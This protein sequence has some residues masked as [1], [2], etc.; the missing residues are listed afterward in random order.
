MYGIG[1]INYLLNELNETKIIKSPDIGPVTTNNP[2]AIYKSRYLSG[3]IKSAASTRS[4]RSQSITSE[5]DQL[6][7]Y[8]RNSSNKRK[9]ED[10][11]FE[12]NFINGISNKKIK[13]IEDENNAY[14]TKELEFDIDINSRQSKIGGY[15]TREIDFDI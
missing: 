9:F 4:L 5:L 10:N 6:D 1:K 3:M 2:D 8:Q 15:I 11:Q 12:S 14:A 7:F 13:P